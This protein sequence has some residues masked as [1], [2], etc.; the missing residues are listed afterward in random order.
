MSGGAK[1]IALLDN[2][3]SAN[4]QTILSIAF[5]QFDDRG[6]N[7]TLAKTL[8]CDSPVNKNIDSPY[9]VPDVQM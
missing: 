5:A 6:N 9:E 4:T 3:L 7:V 1:W 2:I 8:K